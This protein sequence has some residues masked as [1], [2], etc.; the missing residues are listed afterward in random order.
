MSFVNNLLGN[1]NII[2]QSLFKKGEEFFAG[3]NREQNYTKAAEYFEK[4]ALAGNSD[5]A[6]YLGFQYENG[7]G[8][9]QDYTKSVKWYLESANAGNNLAS[10]NL[11]NLYYHGKGVTQDYSEAA[12]WYEKAADQ[13]NQAAAC[14]L[15]NLYYEGNGVP[16]NYA[17]AADWYLKAG[18]AINTI[19]AYYFGTLYRDGDGVLPKDYSLAAK[20]FLK[21]ANEG[22]AKAANQLG[23]RYS[24]GEGV[25]QDSQEAANWYLRAANGGEPWGAYN[26]AQLYDEG[27]GVLQDYSSAIEWYQKAYEGG[28]GEAANIIGNRYY[29]GIKG[30]SQD[31][32]LAA[33]WYLKADRAGYS[34]GACNLACL[35]RDGLGVQQ[36]YSEAVKW[37]LKAAEQG[38]ASAANQL[39]IRF[40][41]GEGVEQ[42]YE[43]AA[44]WY[45]KAAEAQN[46]ED[47][48][49]GAYNLANLYRDGQGVQ[50]NLSEAVKWYTKAANQGLADAAR[51]LG[52]RYEH[53][54]G[55]K[56]DY[57]Q[58]LKWLKQAANSGDGKAANEVGFLYDNQFNNSKEAL[59]WFLKASKSGN[60]LGMRNAGILYKYGR[61]TPSDS[62]EAAKWFQK[63]AELGDANA[64]LELGILYELG[65]GV[66]QNCSEA[67]KCYQIAADANI[68]VGFYDLGNCYLKGIGVPQDYHKAEQLL[69]KAIENGYQ[70]AANNLGYCYENA[71]ADLRDLSKAKN[72]YKKAA[73]AGDEL[74]SNNLKRLSQVEAQAAQAEYDEQEPKPNPEIPQERNDE[75]DRETL[76]EVLDELDSLIGLQSVK[77]HIH[78]LM[79][80]IKTNQSLKEKGIDIDPPTLHMVFYG[81][82]GTGKTTVA[83]LIGKIYKHLGVLTKGQLVEAKRE[84]LV[85]RYI[86]NT[87]KDTKQKIDEALGGVLFIDEAYTLANKGDNDFGQEA[88]D[89]LLAEMENHRDDLAVIVAGYTEPM[90]TFM[91]SNPGLSSRFTNK[92]EFPD[93]TPEELIEILKSMAKLP[94]S[95]DAERYSYE[96]FKH[97]AGSHNFGNARF[98]RNYLQ[99]AHANFSNRYTEDADELKYTLEDVKEPDFKLSENRS[100]ESLIEELNSLV[101]LESVKTQIKE[102]VN[103]AKVDQMKSEAGLS[104][105]PTSNHMIFAGNP[106]TG[107]TTV[108]RILGKLYQAIGLLS[109]GN[110]VEVKRADIVGRYI[111]ETAKET[112]EK[113]EEAMGG[114]LF[115]DEAYTLV[116]GGDKDFG[117]EAIDTLLPEMENHR[118]DFIVI[119]AGYPQPMDNFLDSNPGL[120]SRFSKIINFPDYSAT[121]LTQIFNNLCEKNGLIMEDETQSLIEKYFSYQCAHKDQNF[122]NG[123]LA[124]NYY[125]LV[126]QKQ[127]SRIATTIK[128]PSVEDL[129]TLRREDF[130]AA[131]KE[132]SVSTQ[133]VSKPK[134]GF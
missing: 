70:G 81:N 54:Q 126:V 97:M 5:A 49:W 114:V 32:S 1:E 118:D 15:A 18:N 125:D 57:N 36:S 55:I 33:E 60:S 40:Y 66:E 116:H 86:G 90:R 82:P 98:V 74:G 28:M 65:Q 132:M 16:R 45:L 10:C 108:A 92:I 83:R 25:N 46:E 80:T 134:L 4:A 76:E 130:V 111:G 50:Q 53:G 41:R 84:D 120:R 102:V 12:K 133:E 101:G 11:G 79:N 89:T 6:N 100:Y 14:Y 127:E 20:W 29:S 96:Y 44:E 91:N 52:Y 59:S 128:A 121:E 51:E 112:K 99:H 27:K 8:V 105:S 47:S 26:L 17:T 115:I 30:L 3:K 43:K 85:G 38:L 42:D 104:V 129:T 73:D 64:A 39:G 87:A 63:A 131:N 119:A 122:A 9:S 103:K 31:Y 68:A 35:Y 106:G 67:V 23:I 58:A 72:W 124:R 13:G 56:Q 93:Y 2:G 61:G 24:R 48:E 94:L 77:D 88:I 123:R 69:L 37:Y 7:Q 62:F 117:R 95:E 19:G 109:N 21:A 22:N 110:F 71:P 107:K 75:P 78:Q 34:W 113:I